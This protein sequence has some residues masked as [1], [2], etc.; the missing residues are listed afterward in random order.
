MTNPVNLTDLLQA[1]GPGNLN[2]QQLDNCLESVKTRQGVAMVTFGT[3][4]ISPNDAATDDMPH[5][6]IIW[7]DRDLYQQR[8]QALQRGEGQTYGQLQAQ[9]NEA[10]ALLR[11]A[12][13]VVSEAMPFFADRKATYKVEMIHLLRK[14]IDALLDGQMTVPAMAVTETIRTAPERIWLQVGDQSHCHSEPFPSDTS[15]VSWCAD[16]VMACEVPYVRADLAEPAVLQGGEPCDSASPSSS[17][18]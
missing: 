5:G 9:L 13:V 8:F 14:R 15:E 16:S 17:P 11:E 4:A 2:F 6:I 18:A 3:E 12:G 1:I 7:V 10:L